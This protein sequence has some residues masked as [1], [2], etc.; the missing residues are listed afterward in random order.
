[1]KISK[2]GKIRHQVIFKGTVSY[3]TCHTYTNSDS[4][5]T[6]LYGKSFLTADVREHKKSIKNV[7][8]TFAPECQNIGYAVIQI[9]SM[10][11]LCYQGI[12]LKLYCHNPHMQTLGHRNNPTF[13]FYTAATTNSTNCF[14]IK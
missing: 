8:L 14:Q 2:S 13:A 7:Q 4:Q 10:T 9:G 5:T 1:M 3:T 6:Q 12:M 11:H